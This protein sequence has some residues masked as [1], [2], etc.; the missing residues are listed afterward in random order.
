M[1]EILQEWIAKAK[2]R[3]EEDEKLQQELKDY[4]GIF[5]LDITDGDC[6]YVPIK[7]GEVGD[8]T[9]GVA[10]DARLTVTSDVETMKALM[11]GELGAMKAFALKKIKL[12]GSFEDIIKLRKFLKP[13]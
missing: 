3:I 10:D 13:D 4:D 2:K 7:N 8:L 6:Y 9:K 5:Q 11:S 12:R 1:E